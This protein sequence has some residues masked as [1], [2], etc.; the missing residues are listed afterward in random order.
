MSGLV[1]APLL[2][3]L[4][5]SVTSTLAAN[6]LKGR[7]KMHTFNKSTLMITIVGLSKIL[8]IAFAFTL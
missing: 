8:F 3:L 5:C 4:S 1:L 7:L 2:S 6:A